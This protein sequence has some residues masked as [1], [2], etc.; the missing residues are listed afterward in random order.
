MWEVLSLCKSLG[1]ICRQK[2]MQTEMW[3]RVS[4]E[5]G[6]RSSGC[7]AGTVYYYVQYIQLII[8]NTSWSYM[9]SADM[10]SSFDQ[11]SATYLDFRP[12]FFFFLQSRKIRFYTALISLQMNL[13]VKTEKWEE[14]RDS[15]D[16][17]Q[18]ES[19]SECAFSFLA[20]SALATKLPSLLSESERRFQALIPHQGCINSPS[21]LVSFFIMSQTVMTLQTDLHCTFPQTDQ[22]QSVKILFCTLQHL[23]FWMLELVFW[24]LVVVL[25]L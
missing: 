7:P 11:H 21:A 4:T 16:V 12:V 20:F 23:L 19:S 14:R 8:R 17:Q 22:L 5:W 10:F 9:S 13:L 15:L 25:V 1:K 6:K 2:E 24:V 18:W 3:S